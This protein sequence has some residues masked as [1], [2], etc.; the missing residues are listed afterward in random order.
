MYKNILLSLLV[1]GF[2]FI[3]SPTNSYAQE[4]KSN[5]VLPP[6][7]PLE[8]VLVEEI[9]SQRNA[10]GDEVLLVLRDDLILMGDTYLVKGTPVLGRVL[11]CKAGKSWGRSGSLEIEIYSISPPYG[12]PIVLS[13]G[14]E[15]TQRSKTGKMILGLWAFGLIGGGVKGKKITIP[16][17]TELT[18]FTDAE[19]QIANVPMEEM[20]Q[21]TDAWMKKKIINNFLKFTWKRKCNVKQ[22]FE[23]AQYTY[24]AE[25]IEITPLDDFFY[26][27]DVPV[28][29][30]NA[31]FTFRPFDDVHDGGTGFKPLK[32]DNEVAKKIMKN[33]K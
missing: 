21:Q 13:E 4:E 29:S 5:L 28:G 31:I 7:T 18:L 17:G 10:V 27:I 24:D 22:A 32:P 8:L 15:E 11:R 2:I 14:L 19:G 20:R 9:Y 33:V 23:K 1:M 30:E 26:R 6:G 25:N 3:S 16:A 12:M